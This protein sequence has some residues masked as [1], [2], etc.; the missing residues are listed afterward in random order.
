VKKGRSSANKDRVPGKR[1]VRA[2]VDRIVGSADFDSSRRSID[3]LKFVVEMALSGRINEISQQA[4]AEAVF[5]RGTDFDP[6]TDPIVRM[7]AGRVRRSLEHYYLTAGA[8]DPV[9]ID[10]PKGSYVPVFSFRESD[11]APSRGPAPSIDIEADDWPTLLVS[12]LRNLT[13][14]EEI[15]FIAQ[16]L[17]YDL[18]AELSRDASVHVFLSPASSR[19]QQRPS[20]RFELA[21]AIAL[22]GDDLKINL[23]LLDRNT[24]RQAWAHTYFCPAGPDQGGRL[25]R[26]VQTTVAM[27]TE[28]QGILSK[29]FSREPR[30][31]PTVGDAYLAILKYLRFELTREAQAFTE[32]HTALKQAVQTHPDC[33]LCWSYL[34]RLGAGHW[35]L[36]LPGEAIPIED[37]VA[38]AR[39]G[40]GLA[41]TDVRCRA[42]MAYVFLV[43][44]E[45]E[46]ARHEAE[47]ALRL[48][49]I[50]SIWLDAVGY[51]LTLSG[52]FE[53][54]P[55]LIRKALQINPFPRGVC[56]SALWLDALR[57]SD[58]EAALA[59]ASEFAPDVYFWQPL[60]KAVA[61]VMNNRT[62]EAA[63]AVDCLLQIKPDF[64]QH[65]HWLI[66]R[67]IKFDDLVRR[68][69]EALDAA[70]L[71][72]DERSREN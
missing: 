49:G 48:S 54:G 68:I 26:A 3:F 5:G 18:A 4:I 59:A 58:A 60:M 8:S 46:L 42:I 1:A 24:G 47:T 65:A 51:L 29:Y 66:T 52:D 64:P 31:R 61:L 36:G 40:V 63:A 2:Q 53:Q 70:G 9:S 55:K 41:P 43:T 6:S 33:A 72:I 30:E 21:G 38:A 16:G 34:A 15:E 39:R 35:S 28:E 69:E 20:A 44:D 7:Q 12:P 14:Q 56:Y 23:H 32:A 17:A 10:L 71:T 22:R 37:S 11:A 45:V 19:A 25:D 27:I 62:D 50:S 13:G 67:H 57:R